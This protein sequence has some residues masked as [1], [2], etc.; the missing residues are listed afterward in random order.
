MSTNDFDDRK[1]LTVDIG[2]E[3]LEVRPEDASAQSTKILS[4]QFVAHEIQ[5]S[6]KLL[7]IP[8]GMLKVGEHWSYVMMLDGRPKVGFP[9]R[10]PL[11][12]VPMMRVEEANSKRR[13]PG[14]LV[15]AT[16]AGGLT[17]A[18]AAALIIE[19]IRNGPLSWVTYISAAILML[20]PLVSTISLIK[21]ARNPVDFGRIVIESGIRPRNPS[22]PRD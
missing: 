17:L 22:G 20:A 5:F 10:T 4:G 21:M 13:R 19:T 14:L 7:E 9:D 11:V 3:I 15:G 2:A 16:I 1:P 18:I 8:A 12:D 6:G